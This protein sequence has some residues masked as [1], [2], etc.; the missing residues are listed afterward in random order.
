MMSEDADLQLISDVARTL[1][2][3]DEIDDLLSFRLPYPPIA[4][5]TLDRIVLTCLV[6]EATPPGSLPGLVKWCHER[7]LLKWPLDLPP[8]VF[9][10]KSLL[11]D[12]S[13]GVL[14]E[15]CVE[16]AQ[17][18]GSR[19]PLGEAAAIM[20]DAKPGLAR[21]ENQEDYCQLRRFLI[22]YPVLDNEV[23]RQ[24]GFT[25]DVG[26]F[27]ELLNSLYQPASARYER[28]GGLISCRECGDL[29][30]PVG[31]DD[32]SCEREACRRTGR[33]E[34]G[35]IWLASENVRHLPRRHR[36][37]VGGPARVAI[38]LAGHPALLA[39]P[40]LR[41]DLWPGFG[42]YDLRITTPDDVEATVR[43]VDW[44]NPAL[45]GMASRESGDRQT[46][47]VIPDYRIDQDPNYI[48]TVVR[49]DGGDATRF[50]SESEVIRRIQD[51][52]RKGGHGA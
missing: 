35:R 52:H 37:F 28:D 43:V 3:L 40:G 25:V 31:D 30:A 11:L 42:E 49:W 13:S 2:A 8:E 26:R 32:W 29:M 33:E 20:N 45:L 36:Q 5:R 12:P 38:R 41:A 10:E 6:D 14:T 21:Q 4:Q 23:M 1:V 19:S 51:L 24:V 22:D 47:H 27:D 50:C 16:L 46:L 44:H 15:L 48:A 17:L 39:M 34:I 7:P 9:S 18:A